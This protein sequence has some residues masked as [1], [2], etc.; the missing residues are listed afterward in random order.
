MRF[1]DKDNKLEGQEDYTRHILGLNLFFLGG[2]Q[3]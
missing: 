3:M 1:L 2:G